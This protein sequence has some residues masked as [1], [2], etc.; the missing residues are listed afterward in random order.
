[1]ISANEILGILFLSF[2]SA[3]SVLI[4]SAGLDS[5]E[6]LSREP[7]RVP[8]FAAVITVS[9]IISNAM[10]EAVLIY[11]IPIFGITPSTLLDGTV[12]VLCVIA[13]AAAGEQLVKRRIP[14]LP[15]KMP[16][17]EIFTVGC[18]S[19]VAGIVLLCR[20]A[21]TEFDKSIIYCAVISASVVLVYYAI[22]LW[23][24][25]LRQHKLADAFR[26][27]PILF[28]MLGLAAMVLEGYGGITLPV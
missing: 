2:F 28:I 14:D 19:A 23:R 10:A 1:M 6:R 18:N 11:I 16:E 17:G 9:S 26:G 27:A 22:S 13:A 4:R 5:A 25:D 20:A 7:H 15:E 3:N 24:L 12:I 8:I 21:T